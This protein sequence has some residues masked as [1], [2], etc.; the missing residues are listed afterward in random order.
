MN[1]TKT[2]R[3]T[4]AMKFE[5]IK[6][7][8]SGEEQPHAIPVNDLIDA[9]TKELGLLAKKN[10]SGSSRGPS[11]TQKKNEEYKGLILEFLAGRPDGAT[12][13]EVLR[14][15]PELSEFN[16]QKPAA[17]LRQL[18]P[19]GSKQ[20]VSEKKGGKTIFKLA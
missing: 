15:I 3:I 8:L 5:D 20:V 19:D 2:P 12:C 10:S 17:L 6:A 9:L 14:G 4:K 1:E 13:S 7:I 18:G 16:V 11:E